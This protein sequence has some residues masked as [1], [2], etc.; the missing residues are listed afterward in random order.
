MSAGEIGHEQIHR[1]NQ[2]NCHTRH[3]VLVSVL[4]RLQVAEAALKVDAAPPLAPA[5][6]AAK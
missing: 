2:D 3:A 1:V 4:C 6:R 5:R